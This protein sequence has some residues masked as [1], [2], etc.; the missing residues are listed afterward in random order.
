MTVDEHRHYD[1]PRYSQA[2]IW[3]CETCGHMTALFDMAGELVEFE[4]I[5]QGVDSEENG[6]EGEV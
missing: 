1:L 2:T 6:P 3:V 5:P 4:G